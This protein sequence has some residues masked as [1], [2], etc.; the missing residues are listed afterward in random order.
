MWRELPTVAEIDSRRRNCHGEI[1]K[2]GIGQSG[3]R[4][5]RAQEGKIEEQL[6]EASDQPET[7]HRHRTLR[8]TPRGRQSA[9]EEVIVEDFVRLEEVLRTASS[10]HDR[11]KLRGLLDRER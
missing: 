9:L 3:G 10:D 11:K 6:W 5:A 1:W 4:T 2:E 8:S 7:G